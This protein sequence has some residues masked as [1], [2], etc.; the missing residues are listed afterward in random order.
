MKGIELY[1][2]ALRLYMGSVID[3]IAPAE[4]DDEPSTSAKAVIGTGEWSDLSGLLLPLSEEERLADDIRNGDME[5]IQDVTD[6]LNSCHEQYE[7]WQQAWATAMITDYYGIAEITEQDCRTILADYDEA[8]EE[9]AEGIMAD[10]EKEFQMGDIEQDV[11]D[12]FIKQL[13]EDMTER[14]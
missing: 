9:W 1:D 10:A 5:S 8:R 4:S 6:R 2:M 3:T 12:N 14:K 11:Y 7:A 13:K